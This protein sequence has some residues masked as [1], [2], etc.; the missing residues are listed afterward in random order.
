[1]ETEISNRGSPLL[2]MKPASEIRACK[3]HSE[4][5]RRRRQRINGHL[6]T[7]RTLLPSAARMDKATLL[8]EVVRH[9]RELRG[10]ASDVAGDAPGEGDEV[11]VE[12]SDGAVRA[13]VCCADRPGLM[14][15]MSRAIGSVRAR[16]VRAEIATIGGRTRSMVELEMVGSDAVG[17]VRTHLQDALR[18]VLLGSEPG[19]RDLVGEKFKRPR[20]SARS[21]TTYL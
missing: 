10:L 14:A 3:S 2:N 16:V 8:G 20:L 5:E 1:M 12:D 13:W 21:G 15:E 9:V 17:S 4:A 19:S 6:A 11:G 7:L 18:S